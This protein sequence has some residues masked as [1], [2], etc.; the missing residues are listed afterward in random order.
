VD[1]VFF[2]ADVVFP[3]VAIDK[4]RTPYLF[5]LGRHMA[6][7]ERAAAIEALAVVCGHGPVEA[8]IGGLVMLNRGVAKET[9]D[10]VRKCLTG[11]L[12]LEQ[13]CEAVFNR[14]GAMQDHIS[15]YL[16]RPTI[17]AYLAYLEQGGVIEHV[18][19]RRVA[20]WRMR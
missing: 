8:D 7:M 13:I 19:E 3:R 5:D 20:K 4:C 18:L 10:E 6:S 1:D 14:G 15:Y 17:G 9:L 12:T 11:P 2:C 16:L